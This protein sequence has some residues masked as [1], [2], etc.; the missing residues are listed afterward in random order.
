MVVGDTTNSGQLNVVDMPIDVATP[1]L[2]YVTSP[3]TSGSSEPLWSN[4]GNT[5]GTVSW[6]PTTQSFYLPQAH[7]IYNYIDEKNIMKI[8]AEELEKQFNNNYNNNN[9][10]NNND[11]NNNKLITFRNRKSIERIL[12]RKPAIR[13][14]LCY[15]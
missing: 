2:M 3:G 9:S 11:S 13:W 1:T 7:D 14:A 8:K 10:N 4:S 5:D 6:A 12:C 15:L